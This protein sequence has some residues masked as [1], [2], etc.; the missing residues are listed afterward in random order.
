MS[1][2]MDSMGMQWLALLNKGNKLWCSDDLD[3]DEQWMAITGTNTSVKIHGVWVNAENVGAAEVCFLKIFL[4][5]TGPTAGD[6]SKVKIECKGGEK[7]RIDFRNPLVLALDAA[8]GAED[9]CVM[10]TD[11]ADDDDTTDPQTAGAADTTVEVAILF[12]EV[13]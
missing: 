10:V 4:D 8:T 11:G 7:Q 3:A 9:L 13:A 5:T 2:V 12:E 6:D 1:V